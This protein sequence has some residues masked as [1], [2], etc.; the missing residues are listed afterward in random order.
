MPKEFLIIFSSFYH[1]AENPP[2]E[3]GLSLL[4]MA[5]RRC[6]GQVR[7][8]SELGQGTYIQAVFQHSHWDRAPLGDIK[9]TL[10]TLISANPGLHLEYLHRVNDKT[11]SL[12][13]RELREVLGEEIPLND[14]AV[15]GWLEEYLIQGFIDLYGGENK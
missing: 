14:L 6:N 15:L 3:L 1:Y 5:A 7:V 12:D 4:D 10:I 2:G 11:F 9:A 13:T 8:N